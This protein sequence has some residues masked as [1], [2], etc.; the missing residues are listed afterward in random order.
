MTTALVLSAVLVSAVA[1]LVRA[2]LRQDTRG[3]WTFKPI[4]S[5]AFV[6]IGALGFAHGP[7]AR[8]YS[9]LVLAGLVL[10]TAG[11][12]LLIRAA[13][14][15]LFSLGL[16]SFL[17]AHVA[18]S[19][20]FSVTAAI[21]WVDAAVAVPLLLVAVVLFLRFKANLGPMKIPVAAYMVVISFMVDRAL[22][23]AASPSI[24][25]L[26]SAL[27]AGG[28]ISFY[29]S[30]LML[31]WNRYAAAFRLNRLSL[32]FYYGGQAAIAFS[33]FVVI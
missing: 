5:A 8:L 16:V 20:A 7:G 1:L 27:I 19:L 25:A 31:A 13:A 4:A 17:L 14:P 9:A 30:D 22:G 24:G 28:A 18:Y 26:A 23:V 3:I 32:I 15:R 33:A 2:E 21:G 12:L 10:S 11:D 29:I 6:A